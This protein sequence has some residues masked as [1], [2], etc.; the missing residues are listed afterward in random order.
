MV[1]FPENPEPMMT[2][3]NRWVYILLAALAVSTFAA[4]PSLAQESTVTDNTWV[5]RYHAYIEN[6][7]FG[8]VAWFDRFFEDDLRK[9]LGPPRSS[10]RWTNDFRWDQENKFKYRTRVRASIRLPHLMR[11]W[12]LV[13]TGENKG[14]PT[15][16]RPEDPGNP[17][18]D[19]ASQGRRAST[20]LVYDLHQSRN[21]IVDLGAGV[22]VKLSPTA[23]VRAR[24][25]HTRELAYS[26]IGRL[27]ATPFWDTKDGFGESNQI[28]FERQLAPATLM[29]W[30]NS[31]TITEESNG[32]NWGTELS[33]LQRLSPNSAITFAAN[34]SG[35]TRPS[36]V[37]Q[38]Y[39]AYTRYRRYFLR[40]WLF[41]ELEPD[42]NW[43][44]QEGGGRKTVLGGT[45][46]LEINFTGREAPPKNQ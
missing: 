46:R 19:V 39:R 7:L 25:L 22:R 27:A 40:Y 24:F 4:A 9:D 21:T 38:N 20:E 29:R 8:T 28:D 18:L 41:F 15:A 31:A 10:L 30:S 3:I 37:V 34:A 16:I 5:D 2:S 45:V 33:V 1:N 13:I 23:Y 26:V 11:K 42:I 17:G 14:D 6:D 32:W 12:R 36:T 43:P 35:P 44:R